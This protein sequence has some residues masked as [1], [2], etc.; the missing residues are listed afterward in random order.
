MC[1]GIQLNYND[2][3]IIGRTMELPGDI[4]Y[5]INY[6]P[7]G[8]DLCDNLLGGKFESKYRMLGIAFREEDYLKDGVNEHGLIGITNEFHGYNLFHKEPNPEKTNI[9]S[10]HFFQYILGTYKSINELVEDIPN[11]QLTSHDVNGKEQISPLFHWMFTDSTK[12]CVIIQPKKRKIQV[13]ENPYHLMTNSPAFGYH[14]KRLEETFDLQNLE[15]FNSAKDLPGA[16][17]SNSRFLK[18]Y[19]LKERSLPA[20]TREQA[21]S[22]FFNILKTVSLPKG[23]IKE[24]K[25]FLYTRYT[26]GYDTE[27]LELNI[28]DHKNHN[29]YSIGLQDIKNIDEQQY[30]YLHKKFTSIPLI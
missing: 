21:Y 10:Y 9:T 26:C 18:A 11:L 22:N 7:R 25:G 2:H 8:Y 23:F 28:Q 4:P 5:L 24:K 19:Y 20:E 6:I 12:R 27:K 13:Y 16:Y 30:F 15:K 3:C 14:I 29:I 1:T 17:D